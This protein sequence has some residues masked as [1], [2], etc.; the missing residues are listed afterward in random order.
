VDNKR[1]QLTDLIAGCLLLVALLYG[2]T[3]RPTQ[4]VWLYNARIGVWL[5]LIALSVILFLVGE[6]K[7]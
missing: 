5:V 7:G 3:V 6:A 4:H 2:F 1:P